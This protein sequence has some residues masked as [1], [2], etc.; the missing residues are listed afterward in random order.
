MTMPCHRSNTKID[1]DDPDPDSERGNNLESRAVFYRDRGCK[2]FYHLERN[3]EPRRILEVSPRDCA[4]WGHPN[5][6]SLVN[7]DYP[8]PIQSRPG[9]LRHLDNRCMTKDNRHDADYVIL[10]KPLTSA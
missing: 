5:L 4:P 8:A 1:P 2:L 7:H 10:I 3:N 6:I 9:D